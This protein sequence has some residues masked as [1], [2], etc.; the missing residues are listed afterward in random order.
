MLAVLSKCWW[1][2]FPRGVWAILFSVA[3]LAWPGPMI[4]IL[5]IFFGACALIAGHKDH[6]NWLLLPLRGGIGMAFGLRGRAAKAAA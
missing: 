5:V 3:A 4:Q 2:V 6:A 1:L